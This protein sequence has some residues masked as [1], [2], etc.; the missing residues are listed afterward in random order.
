[1]TDID[2]LCPYVAARINTFLDNELDEVTADEV[3]AHLA[4]CERCSDEAEV[5]TV[6][7]ADVKRAYHPEPAP[8]AL[9]ARITAEIHR[10]EAAMAASS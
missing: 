4:A 7:R 8:A 2:D 5:W 9:I 10:A 1:V 3:R 6:I